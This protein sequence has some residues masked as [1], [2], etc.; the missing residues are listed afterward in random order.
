[1]YW[2]SHAHSRAGGAPRGGLL[3]YRVRLSTFKQV[4]FAETTFAETGFSQTNFAETKC[5]LAGAR[6]LSNLKYK[7]F[8]S[9]F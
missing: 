5:G 9:E 3:F 6:P 7:V 1:M 8:S 2:G 4:I